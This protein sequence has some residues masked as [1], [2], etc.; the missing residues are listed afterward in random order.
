MFNN[1]NFFQW[2]VTAVIALF[3]IGFLGWRDVMEE[4]IAPPGPPAG[5]KEQ[6]IPA[7][8]EGY[9][10]AAN[11][12]ITEN[13]PAGKETHEEE[14]GISEDFTGRED[15]GIKEKRAVKEEQEEGSAAAESGTSKESASPN[16]TAT[17]P[18]PWMEMIDRLSFLESPIPGARISTRDTHLPGAPR[19]YRSGTHEGLDYYYGYCGVKIYTGAPVYAA[20]EGI[21]VRVDSD[22]RELTEEEREE[23]LQAVNKLGFTPEKELDRLRGRQVWVLHRDNIVTRYAHLDEVNEDLKVGNKVSRGDFLGTI[24]NSGTSADV[25]GAEMGA[26]LHFEIWVEGHYLG[27]GLPPSKVRTLWEKILPEK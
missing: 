19:P 27:E 20:A 5:E 1:S 23:I 6:E 10:G 4:S 26:H 8:V 25:A 11:Y 21:V 14:K 13:L 24:G 17:P 15:E 16:F 18:L 7:E 2:T 9:S 12:G 3:L 22:Y